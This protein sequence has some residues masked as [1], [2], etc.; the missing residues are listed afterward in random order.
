MR[1][2][3]EINKIQQEQGLA[4]TNDDHMSQRGEL[5]QSSANQ[6][7]SLNAPLPSSLSLTDAVVMLNFCLE[8][9]LLKVPVSCVVKG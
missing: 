7:P 5:T 9:S 4:R 1:T 8:K 6:P 2:K 3:G